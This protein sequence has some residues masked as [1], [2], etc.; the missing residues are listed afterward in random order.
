M[1]AL[2]YRNYAKAVGHPSNQ[3]PGLI[4]DLFPKQLLRELTGRQI[5][6]VVRLLEATYMDGWSAAGGGIGTVMHCEEYR[7]ALL[8]KL[9]E[10]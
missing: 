8:K 9:G 10:D 7:R 2:K 5:G 3:G 1:N 4:L 6:L